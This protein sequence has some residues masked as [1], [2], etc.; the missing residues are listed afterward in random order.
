MVHIS[1]FTENLLVAVIYLKLLLDHAEVDRVKQIIIR[2]A[3]VTGDLSFDDV[4]ELLRSAVPALSFTVFHPQASG[5]CA[6][7]LPR[8]CSRDTAGCKEKGGAQEDQ[9][10]LQ[11]VDQCLCFSG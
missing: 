11:D 9:P 2:G 1:F 10:Q 4:S 7:D 6:R 5:C 3:A 8:V